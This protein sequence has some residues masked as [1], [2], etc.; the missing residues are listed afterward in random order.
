MDAPL[1]ITPDLGQPRNSLQ[2]WSGRPPAPEVTPDLERS[3]NLRQLWSRYLP[4]RGVTG[5]RSPVKFFTTLVPA[6]VPVTTPPPLGG[7]RS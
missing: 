2:L 6:L 4:P 1:G 7:I 5:F 3:S